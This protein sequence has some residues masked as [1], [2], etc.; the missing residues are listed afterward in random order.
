[1]RMGGSASTTWRA[2]ARR[3]RVAVDVPGIGPVIGDVAW[4]G[5]WFFLIREH[6]RSIDLR[7][8][9]ALTDFC[10]RVRAA[11]NAQGH[12]L[13]DHVEL[14]APAKRAG[15]HSR[16]F[17]LCP[18]KAYDRSPCGTGTSAK[19]ACLAAEGTLAEGEAWMQESLIGSTFVARY[20]WHDR[21]K[22]EI[23]PTITGIAHVTGEDL[24]RLDPDD[25]SGWEFDRERHMV[26][27]PDAARYCRT[28]RATDDL[29]KDRVASAL[30]PSPSFRAAHVLRVRMA[31]RGAIRRLWGDDQPAGCRSSN[32]F[33]AAFGLAPAETQAAR[34]S[35]EAAMPPKRVNIL[36]KTSRSPDQ[37][38]RGLGGSTAR[39]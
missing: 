12:P 26:L 37:Y 1:M 9:E 31:E 13:V 23:V 21:V 5:N 20:R 7:H 30:A 28:L 25:P 35:N 22:G 27:A 17:V 3:T 11:I 15:A 29:A 34:T 36:I 38:A 4:G 39:G 18:G 8:V 2:I 19:L 16:N 10:S 32:L 6:D 24:L 33:S 14:F